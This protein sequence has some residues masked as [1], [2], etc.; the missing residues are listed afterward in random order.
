[1]E[2]NNKISIEEI[3]AAVDRDINFSF[4]LYYEEKKVEI[5]QIQE[6]N[7]PVELNE[8]IKINKGIEIKKLSDEPKVYVID[9]FIT[10]DECAHF[11][12]ISKPNLQQALVSNDKTGFV[13]Q[14]RTGKNCWIP[15]SI[16][17]VTKEV[18]ERIAK[19][20]GVELN[21]SEQYQVI[22]YGKTEEYRQHYDSW[23][24]D[25]SD[26]SKRCMRYGGQRMYTALCYLND[27]EEGGHTRFTKLD[28]NVEAKKGRLL[29]FHN[30][31][32]G[33]NK[34]HILSE[35]AG[36]PVLKGEKWAFNLWFREKPR[37]VIVYDPDS[38]K[39]NNKKEIAPI[40]KKNIYTSKISEFHVNNE[41]RSLYKNFIMERE[42]EDL[43]KYCVFKEE[44]EKK[45]LI[46]WGANTN[47]E[48]FLDKIENIIKI[49]KSHFENINFVKYRRNY[50]HQSHLDAYDFN[51]EVGKRNMKTKGLSG[52]RILTISG[53]LTTNIKYKFIDLNKDIV[54]EKGGLLIYNNV[55]NNSDVRNEK[56][57]KEIINSSE[58]EEAIIFH[59]YVR[60]TNK[61]GED[62][63]ESNIKQFNNPGV[64]TSVNKQPEQIF[65]EKSLEDFKDTLKGAYSS[66][67]ERDSKLG[68][69]SLKFLNKANWNEVKNTLIKLNDISKRDNGILNKNLLKD[70]YIFD[71]YNPV[72]LNNVIN[73]EA[74]DILKNYIKGAINRK[75]I[76]LGDRQSNRFRAR[77]ETVTRFLHYEVL[78][79]IRKITKKDVRPTYTYLSCYT[80]DADLP[81]HTDQPDCEY[82]VSFIIDKPENSNWP[83]YLDKKKQ[84][85]KHKGR[86][87]HTPKKEDC[88]SC[89][90]D[91]GGLM[92]FNGTDHIHYREPSIYDYYN[93]VLLHYRIN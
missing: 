72:I 55:Q 84:P 32:E 85:H 44:E 88:I 64:N 34:K 12:N 10:N 51:T 5:K 29:I 38:K 1:M 4:K 41:E 13:S 17:K 8:P 54:I 93:I 27:V 36:M 24:H 74:L 59:L 48:K 58:D 11:I 71:E 49:N 65:T 30:V 70:E 23:E 92:I 82:T 53:C 21:T 52:Q 76:D 7:K 91:S 20:V 25:G 63:L 78:E 50:I 87:D 42:V 89:D 45:K 73:D 26:K 69:N 40:E 61:S 22:Y 6:V 56:L 47:I 60:N 33:T 16:D 3:K 86:A 62:V 81:A 9:N 15:H 31:Y 80:K 37:S 66:I 67:L 46:C 2:K 79:L 28:I 14:G 90:C 68:Y 57:R 19:Q 77:N 39:V 35:H 83:I 75:E 43:K 18:G